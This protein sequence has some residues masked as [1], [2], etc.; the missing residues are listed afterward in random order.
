VR[1][2][3]TNKIDERIIQLCMERSQ[4]HKLDKNVPIYPYV[5]EQINKEF[6]IV[7][8]NEKLRGISRKYRD[9]NKLNEYFEL[10]QFDDKDAEAHK[11][12]IEINKDG[13]QTSDV[14]LKMSAEQAKDTNFLL[15]AHGYS[16]DDWELLS[17]RNNIWNVYSKQDGVQ[18]LYSSKIVVKP[19]KDS[20][21]LEELQRHFEEFSMN[22]KSPERINIQYSENGKMLEVNIADLHLGKLCWHG[23]TG[24]DYD[25][26]IAKRNYLYIINDI[27]NKVKGYQF[28]KVLFVWCND[29]FHFDTTLNTTTK[30]TR[31]DTDL[32]WQKLFTTGVEMLVE[33]IDLLSTIAPVHTFY[34]GSNHD[35]MTSFYAIMYLSAWFRKENYAN[36]DVSPMIRKYIE[37][38]KNLIGFSHG[39][40]DFKRLG[41]LMA[42]EAREVW[43]RTLYHEVHAAHIHSEHEIDED[44][45]VIKRRISSAT[46]TDAWHYESGFVGA[47]KKAQSFIW[48]KENGL[49]AIL[50]TVIK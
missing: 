38:G 11:S 49:E 48:D 13:S 40:D 42:I 17:A 8:D 32:R 1:F 16:I 36:I 45:G 21:S 28:E 4:L 12:T 50:N 27:I 22:Y 25:W 47:V 35:K 30:G 46:S 34:L 5:S 29:F 3:L 31:Q 43:G 23:E 18:V 39:D 2:D 7:Y 44:N 15:E 19:R 24:E 37:F 14:L 9:A 33:G 41:S 6:N 20:I 26:Q 10:K